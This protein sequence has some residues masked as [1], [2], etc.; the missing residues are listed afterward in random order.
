MSVA[1]ATTEIL[2][3]RLAREPFT[4]PAIIADAG[5]PAVRAY[6]EYLEM[7]SSA[8]LGGRRCWSLDPPSDGPLNYR[9]LIRLGGRWVARGNPADCTSLLA[10]RR[11]A[12]QAHPSCCAW[13][14]DGSDI[15]NRPDESRGS[16]D[17]LAA[18]VDASSRTTAAPEA[19]EP[20][21]FCG[22]S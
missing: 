6:R 7:S 1:A 15:M 5:E 12:N 21:A 17:E 10:R 20:P 8:G 14:E 4:V 22:A 9:R 3:L 18:V 19:I 2:P 16:T 13:G 11:P